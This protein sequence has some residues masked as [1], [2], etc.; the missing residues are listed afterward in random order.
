MVGILLIFGVIVVLVMIMYGQSR[1]GSNTPMGR[2]APPTALDVSFSESKSMP[3]D[4]EFGK[5]TLPSIEPG[6]RISDRTNPDK[7][8]D[9]VLDR[10]S[11]VT[12]G[13]DSRYRSIGS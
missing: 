11:V 6:Q 7:W 8:M 2:S 5:H 3:M 10:V 9:F 13:G 1:F 12:V 4:D